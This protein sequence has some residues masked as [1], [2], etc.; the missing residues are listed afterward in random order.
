MFK[1]IIQTVNDIGIIT[2]KIQL[3]H[4]DCDQ[5]TVQQ[6]HF[7]ITQDYNQNTMLLLKTLTMRVTVI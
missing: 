4:F 2:N 1:D 3:N 5:L 7:G 6:N